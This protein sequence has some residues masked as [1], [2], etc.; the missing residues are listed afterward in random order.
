MTILVVSLSMGTLAPFAPFIFGGVS[1]AVTGGLTGGW[2]GALIGAGLGI[3]TTGAVLYGGPIVASGLFWGGAAYSYKTGG[4]AGVGDFASALAGGFLGAHIG[5]QVGAGFMDAMQS[6][7]L[8]NQR[9]SVRIG[10]GESDSDPQILEGAGEHNIPS[11]E[12]QGYYDTGDGLVK[13]PDTREL[14]IGK[15]S[16]LEKPGALRPGEYRLTWP[17]QGD[18]KSNWETNSRLLRVEMQRRVPIR[19]ISSDEGGNFIRAE[20]NL[21]K[22]HGW[23]KENGYWHPPDN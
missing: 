6:G 11:P 19:D 15:L 21:L 16:D 2:R 22:N 1:G 17:N 3:A 9:G 13:A 8:A 14:V 23:E 10:N 20:R 5:A 18:P 7:S 4:W 12:Q